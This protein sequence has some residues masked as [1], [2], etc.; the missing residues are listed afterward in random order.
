M[1]LSI[2]NLDIVKGSKKLIHNFNARM[3]KGTITGLLGPNGVGKSSFLRVLAGLDKSF[4]GNNPNNEMTGRG[5]VYKRV[6]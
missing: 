1:T 2:D 6:K 3:S 5:L 4:S